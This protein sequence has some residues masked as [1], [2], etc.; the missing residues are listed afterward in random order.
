[1]FT[2]IKTIVISGILIFLVQQ[3]Y[4][5]I[6]TNVTPPKIKVPRVEKYKSMFE[7]VANASKP[8]KL[9]KNT[10]ALAAAAV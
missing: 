9:S 6:R 10:K 3:I 5:F 7:E 4:S 2:F 8:S 1:M